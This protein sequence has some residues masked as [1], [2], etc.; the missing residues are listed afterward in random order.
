MTTKQLQADI[1]LI[2]NLLVSQALD[3]DYGTEKN[4]E[5]Y[6]KF[7]RLLAKLGDHDAAKQN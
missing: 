1:T 7:K 6:R 4:M 3:G 5:L 2:V